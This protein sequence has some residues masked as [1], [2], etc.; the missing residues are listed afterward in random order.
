[1]A[2]K[3]EKTKIVVDTSKWIKKEALGLTILTRGYC[4]YK[5]VFYRDNDLGDLF[6]DI[7]KEKKQDNFREFLN[8]LNGCWSVILKNEN[9]KTVTLAVDRQRSI[10]LFYRKSNKTLVVSDNIYDLVDKTK[11]K[12][13]FDETSEYQFLLTG[14]VT[15]EKTLIEDV[16]QV[17]PSCYI[18][19]DSDL[20]KIKHEYF[21]YF[22]KQ[23]QIKDVDTLENDLYEIILKV[24]T[25]L[26]L[27]CKEKQVIV[28]LSGGNDSRLILWML[29]ESGVKNVLCY[30]YG[31]DTNPQ[32]NI[33]KALAESFNYKWVF[34]EYSKEKWNE[35]L[36]DKAAKDYFIFASNGVSLPHIQDYPAVKELHEK[37][38]ISGKA[39]FLP[40]HVGDAWANEF[41]TKS[42]DEHYPLPPQEYHSGFKDIF[43]SHLISF[44]VYRHFMFFPISKKDW[45]KDE[46][47]KVIDKVRSEIEGGKQERKEDIWK[48][49]EWILKGRTS[50]W[51]V[52]SVR[53]YEYY[54]ASFYL[55]LADYELINFFQKL[56]LEHIIDR[57]LYARVVKKIFE[58]D[59]KSLSEVKILSGGARNRG[60]KRQIIIF[61]KKLGIYDIF[62]RYKHKHRQERNLNFEHWFTEGK[63]S[64]EI[65][66]GEILENHKVHK[67]IPQKILVILRK[68]FN[69]PS[70]VIHCN[71]VFSIIF[72]ATFKKHFE[73]D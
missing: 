14:F 52:N 62:E 49:L 65:K 39:M 44:L 13:K 56:P 54:N 60:L 67:H 12:V 20:N 64:E 37:G 51:I 55:P 24:K 32:K 3:L 5:D 29:K 10:P 41:A 1:M 35:S 46:F 27:A 16:L 50:L 17:E 42:L 22:P 45:G 31:V 53:T 59:K 73:N 38:L 61:T 6:L 19:F 11:Q 57:N 68:F 72:M 30:T 71:G 4:N 43:D 2:F 25:R 66:F 9:T 7:F 33:A 48:A 15:G 36:S 70:Y 18:D 28:P 23:Q 26:A 40:G 47:Q 63:R 34:I 69:K 21:C 8:K 58:N